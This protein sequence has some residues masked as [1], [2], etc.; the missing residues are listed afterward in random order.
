MSIYHEIKPSRYIIPKGD[1]QPKLP[2][3]RPGSD[4]SHLRSLGVPNRQRRKQ[5]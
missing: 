1:Y 4:H 2:Y 3:R 5:Q